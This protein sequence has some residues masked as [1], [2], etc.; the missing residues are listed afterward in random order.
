MNQQF[1][2]LTQ[3]EIFFGI[4]PRLIKASA[5]GFVNTSTPVTSATSI[6]I[7]PTPVPEIITNQQTAFG[8]GNF[9]GKYKWEIGLLLVGAGIVI[10]AIHE[11]KKQEKKKKSKSRISPNTK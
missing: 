2:P 4:K 7:A 9:I 10:Y 11:N 6:P 8:L 5:G 1:I 3:P